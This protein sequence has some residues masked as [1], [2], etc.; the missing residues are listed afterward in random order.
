MELK[1][2]ER[3]RFIMNDDDQTA[4]D[5]ILNNEHFFDNPRD[6]ERYIYYR[7]I[8]WK[9]AAMIFDAVQDQSLSKIERQRAAHLYEFMAQTEIKLDFDP[10]IGQFYGNSKVPIITGDYRHGLQNRLL[11]RS[12]FNQLVETGDF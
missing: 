5:K 7:I 11:D 4:I 3:D 9:D 10:E 1:N 2:R 12:R 6:L 8:F